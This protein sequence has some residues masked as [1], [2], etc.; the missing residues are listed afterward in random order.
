M[1]VD[2]TRGADSTNCGTLLEPCASIASAFARFSSTIDKEIIDFAP[3]RYRTATALTT[4]KNLKLI[5]RYPQGSVSIEGSDRQ[6]IL[7][8]YAS[9]LTLEAITFVG[10]FQPV[11]GPLVQAHSFCTTDCRID[12][13]GCTFVNAISTAIGGSSAAL[14]I[15][16]FSSTMITSPVINVVNSHFANH[17]STWG[18]ALKVLVGQ[19]ISA[20]SFRISNCSFVNNS[21]L[22]GGALAISFNGVA[23]DSSIRMDSLT[24]EANTNQ[25]DNVGHGG[26]VD[27]TLGN[28]VSNFSVALVDSVISSSKAQQGGI[29]SSTI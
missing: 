8:F 10:R 1:Y 5:G 16:F 24:M 3:G 4:T 14:D 21:M 25:I 9:Q 13:F 2:Q 18:S 23:L 7:Q 27:I 20:A 26:S 17:S 15:A 22:L 12:V 29:R 28:N 11:E 19:D 6:S